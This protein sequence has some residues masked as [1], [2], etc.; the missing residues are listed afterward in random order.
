MTFV[1]RGR[2]GGRQILGRGMNSSEEFEGW[3]R[4]VTEEEWRG[5]RREEIILPNDSNVAW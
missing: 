3:R 4:T 1:E 5:P 2:K